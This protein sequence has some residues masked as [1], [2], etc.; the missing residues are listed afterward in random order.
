MSNHKAILALNPS[1]VLIRGAVA[2]DDKNN[3][4]IY[5]E[6]AVNAWVDPDQYKYSRATAYP[7]IA[8][9][10]DTIYHQGLDAWKAT[11]LAVKEEFPK[12]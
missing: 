10:L 8:D 3:V 5:D 9:Q 7:S 4:V 11:I 12:P 1:V 2:Y 6:A